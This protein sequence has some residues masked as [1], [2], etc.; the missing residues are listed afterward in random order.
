VKRYIIPEDLIKKQ[1]SYFVSRNPS[2]DISQFKLDG[3]NNIKEIKEKDIIKR[4]LSKKIDN[5]YCNII[6]EYVIMILTCKPLTSTN[7]NYAHTL[8]SSKNVRK[9]FAKL[10][11]QEKF[12]ENK[13]QVLSEQSFEDL[14]H[15]IFTSLLLAEN[16]S[17]NYPDVKSITKSTF[18]YYK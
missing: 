12:S 8:L 13:L 1:S 14:F 2:E 3:D 16:N 18:F 11:F 17:E 7:R 15:L 6:E 5:D 9:H 10:L 4:K